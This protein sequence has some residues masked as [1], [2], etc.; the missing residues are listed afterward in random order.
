MKR[1]IEVFTTYEVGIPG[2]AAAAGG[3]IAQIIPPIAIPDRDISMG[4]TQ[5]MIDLT[6]A[7][8]MQVA[9]VDADTQGTPVGANTFVGRAVSRGGGGYTDAD[10][11]GMLINGWTVAPTV[12]AS[13]FY[14]ARG[15][16]P[17]T[18]GARL[19]WTFAEDDPLTRNMI[20]TTSGIQTGL[21]LQNIGGAGVGA[22]F[23]TVRW[24]EFGQN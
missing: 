1:R 11:P 17:A 18:V 5:I 23:V 6:A 19:I 4:I 22:N 10:G 16:L 24:S 2:V 14:F 13:P 20:R 12:N 9:L 8:A 7:T 15:Q 3:V 21:L